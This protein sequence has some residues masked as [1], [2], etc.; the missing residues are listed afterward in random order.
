MRFGGAGRT[1]DKTPGSNELRGGG[2]TQWGVLIEKN[3][4]SPKYVGEHQYHVLHDTEHTCT[5]TVR[6]WNQYCRHQ[7]HRRLALFDSCNLAMST[8]VWIAYTWRA[9]SFYTVVYALFY[10]TNK[11][12]GGER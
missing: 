5:N 6:L 2:A 4:A 10:V 11:L 12:L 7:R 9:T 1:K 3:I 8:N